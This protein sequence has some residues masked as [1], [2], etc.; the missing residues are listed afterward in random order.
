MNPPAE[1]DPASGHRNYGDNEYAR[2]YI[3]SKGTL[4]VV[5]LQVHS[6]TDTLTLDKA[7]GVSHD[8][9][10][11]LNDATEGAAL[12]PRDRADHHVI[13]NF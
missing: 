7:P 11:S 4:T 10:G 1:T 12:V 8:T 6:A 2:I 5:K 9:A 13:K 3:P